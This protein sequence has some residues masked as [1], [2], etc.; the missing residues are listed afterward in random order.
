[1]FSKFHI[2]TW[3][4]EPHFGE[5]NHSLPQTGRKCILCARCAPTLEF[6]SF[7]AADNT[8]EWQCSVG[9]EWATLN[10]PLSPAP[11]ST[12][13]LAANDFASISVRNTGCFFCRFFL[14]KRASQKNKISGTVSLKPPPHHAGRH[15]TWRQPW[16]KTWVVSMR[17]NLLFIIG[18]N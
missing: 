16:E 11:L 18:N 5:C 7:L 3:V 17:E 1:M 6:L 12:Q 8:C 15:W 13:H 9:R 4:H 10:L 2:S 14:R